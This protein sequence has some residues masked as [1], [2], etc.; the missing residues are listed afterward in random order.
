ME[1]YKAD[2]D[3][4]RALYERPEERA[5]RSMSPVDSCT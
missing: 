3:R 2:V 5:A 1:K 4:M